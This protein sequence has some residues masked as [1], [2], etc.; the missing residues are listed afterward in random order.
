ML[1]AADLEPEMEARPADQQDEQHDGQYQNTDAHYG[2]DGLA[3]G[4]DDRI[5]LGG[6]RLRQQH[7]R[8]ATQSQAT[9]APWLA[10]VTDG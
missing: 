2:P 5:R 1:Q 3:T 10:L 6:S 9:T 7:L 4:R 8:K